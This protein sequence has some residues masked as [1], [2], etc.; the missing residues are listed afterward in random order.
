MSGDEIQKLVDKAVAEVTKEVKLN[1]GVAISRRTVGEI[2]DWIAVK[3]AVRL[4]HLT[5]LWN[6]VLD[7]CM[8][9]A[10]MVDGPSK[11]ATPGGTRVRGQAAGRPQ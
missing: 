2:V 1:D 7:V 10:L 5:N 9:R 8:T 4:P 11:V 6:K 3:H